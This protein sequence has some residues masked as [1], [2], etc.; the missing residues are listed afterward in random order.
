MELVLAKTNLEEKA[1]KISLEKLAEK[2]QADNNRVFYFD[3][4]NS[5]KDLLKAV[6]F[7]E[8]KGRKAY[9][10]E[11]KISLDEKDYIYELHII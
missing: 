11:I 10:S 8:N 4:S 5:H 9:L 2:L 7:F 3:P 1:Q 6:S